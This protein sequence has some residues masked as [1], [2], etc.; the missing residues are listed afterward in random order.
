[1]TKIAVAGSTGRVG[2]HVVDVLEAQGHEVV[3][4]SRSTGVDVIT[5]AG[6]AEALEGVESVVDAASWPTSEQEPAT[7]FFLAS[8]A[9]LQ[10]YAERAGVRPVVV[11]SIVGADRFRAGYT[12]WKIPHEQAHLTGPA[13]AT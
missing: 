12:A 5:A 8:A 6:L 9:N 3:P 13:A 11:T 7:E 1:M 10:A 2:R 4:I